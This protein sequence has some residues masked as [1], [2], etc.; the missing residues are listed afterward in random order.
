MPNRPSALQSALWETESKACDQSRKSAKKDSGVS[1]V[2]LRV[3]VAQTNGVEVDLP[4][5]K[6]NCTEE[7][8]SAIAALRR[9]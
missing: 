5:L 8:R 4:A 9:A 1:H 6:P 2:A 7:I 3:C